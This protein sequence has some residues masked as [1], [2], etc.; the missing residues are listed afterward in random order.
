MNN[1]GI[2]S[3]RLGKLAAPLEEACEKYEVTATDVIL[4]ALTLYLPERCGI[5]IP[6]EIDPLP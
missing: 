3:V 1:Q 5:T 4:R 6:E 2:V